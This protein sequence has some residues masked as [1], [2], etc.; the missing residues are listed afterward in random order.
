M[1]GASRRISWIV[2]LGCFSVIAIALLELSFAEGNEDERPNVLLIAIDDLNDWI[3]CL[4]G[5]PDT[6]T[7]NLDRLAGNSLL[8]TNAHS[9]GTMCNPSRI[10]ILWGMRPSTTGFYDNYHQV[11]YE[12][13]FL[14]RYISLPRYFEKHGYKTLSMGKVFHVGTPPQFQIEGESPRNW[15]RGLDV[16]HHEKPDP[17]HASWDFGPQDY[18]ESEFVD[19]VIADWAVDQLGRQHDEPFFLAV[20]F[21]RPHVPFFPPSGVYDSFEQAALPAV[22]DRDWDDIPK[23]ARALTMSNVNIP[24]HDW[25]EENENERWKQAV[26]A[27]LACIRWVDTQMGRV[28]AGL[29]QSSYASNTIVLLFS[30]HGYHLGEKQRWSKFSLWER[31]TRV[32]L[33]IHVPEG[34]RGW[35]HKPV[36]L[37][38]IYPTLVELCGLPNNPDVEGASLAPL[39][40]NPDAPWSHV[41]VSTLGQNN[42]AVRDGR[43]RYIRYADGAEELYDHDRDPNEWENLAGS[44]ISPAH[45]DLIKRLQKRIP[46]INVEQRRR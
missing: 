10:S 37:L 2:R 38:S 28:L 5:H 32:P 11:R 27:Y 8:F 3:G 15:L 7:P 24:T 13:E 18:D 19:Y 41:A 20:G 33:M 40:R 31:T 6:L 23:A 25:F 43:W 46:S 39:I 17:W 4:D 42:H 12:P 30:D 29:E 26:H 34:V 16:R 44:G 14:E 36:E 21:Y 9:Q 1:N 22:E 45:Q 35:T